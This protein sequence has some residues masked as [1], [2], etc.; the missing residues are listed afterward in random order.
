MATLIDIDYP[1]AEKEELVYVIRT[2]QKKV[3]ELR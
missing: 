3:Q 2:L 1:N